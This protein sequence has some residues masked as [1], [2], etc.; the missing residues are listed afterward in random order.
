MYSKCSEQACQYS[1]KYFKKSKIVLICT[2]TNHF[3]TDIQQ[4]ILY[5][6]PQCWRLNLSMKFC[7][8]RVSPIE[9]GLRI[10][11]Y[12]I[13]FCGIRVKLPCFF[14]H[15]LFSWLDCLFTVVYIF[16]LLSGFSFNE[17]IYCAFG[18]FW[19]LLA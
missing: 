15:A 8:L 13:V 17:F 12:H 18:L 16:M 2:L 3:P 7:F 5:F 9:E 1:V 14:F 6:E 19:L 11:R 4:N 10:G